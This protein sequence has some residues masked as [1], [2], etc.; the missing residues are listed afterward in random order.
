M[1]IL[2]VAVKVKP[3]HKEAYI[4]AITEDARSSVRD[5]PGCLRFEVMEDQEDP[6]LIYLVE[7]YRDQ[8]A[9]EAH[10][11][12]PHLLRYREASGPLLAEPSSRR[13]CNNIFPADDAWR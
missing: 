1:Y 5:E 8:A 10:T 12:T 9:F 2:Q 7:V 4:Q 11:K 6:N 3:G 13:I